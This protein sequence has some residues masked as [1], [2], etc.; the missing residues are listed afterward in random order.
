MQ[1]GAVAGQVDPV[2]PLRRGQLHIKVGRHVG[3]RRHPLRRQHGAAAVVIQRPLF[4]AEPELREHGGQ[5][6]GDQPADCDA[7]RRHPR[8]ELVEHPRRREVDL[9]GEMQDGPAG[10]DL[11]R[12]PRRQRLQREPDVQRIRVGGA[13]RAGRAGRR[14]QRVSGAERV[15]G[16]HRAAAPGQRH[17][18]RQADQA[19]ADDRDVAASCCHPSPTVR[20]PSVGRSQSVV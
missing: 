16:D 2:H 15:E 4:R 11:Q 18:G 3:K 20:S 13:D 6:V 14:G 7:L 19:L 10:V 5:S 1:G 9:A 12:A 8:L 17:G